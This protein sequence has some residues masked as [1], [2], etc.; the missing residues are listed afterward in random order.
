MSFDTTTLLLQSINFLVLVVIVWRLLVRPLRG[1]MLERAA[2]ISQQLAQ[3]E[4]DRAELAEARAA[5]AKAQDEVDRAHEAALQTAR[6]EAAVE[7]DRILEEARVTARHDRDALLASTLEEQDR[8]RRRFLHDLVP[9]L[10][11]LLAKLL[12][13]LGDQAHLH[14]VTCDGFASHLERPPERV[15]E[16]IRR[17]KAGRLELVVAAAPPPA[18]LAE[19]VARLESATVDVRVDPSLIAGAQLVVGDLVLDGSVQSQLMAALGEL[20]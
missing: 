12:E 6:T 8:R 5:V 2:R 15:R 17:S 19:T 10:T 20:R 1:H 7:R 11:R 4:R 16:E 18:L 13:E 9:S 3:I 14:Q